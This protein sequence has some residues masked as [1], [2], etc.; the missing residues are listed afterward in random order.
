MLRVHTIYGISAEA[1]RGWLERS[2]ILA[3]GVGLVGNNSLPSH[4]RC[5]LVLCQG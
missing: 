3:L 4:Q 5:R 2:E 1:M